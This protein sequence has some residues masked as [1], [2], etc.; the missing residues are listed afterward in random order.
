MR[1]A[2][3]TVPRHRRHRKIV[4]LAK[5]YYGAR[6]QTSGR[7]KMRY[8]KHGSMHTEIAEPISETFAGCGLSELMP[9]FVCMDYPIRNLF[10]L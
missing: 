4:K 6:N 1:R 7:Q 10:L 9:L 2:N 5:G 8:R 3:S